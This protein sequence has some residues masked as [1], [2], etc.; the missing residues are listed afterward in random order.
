MFTPFNLVRIWRKVSQIKGI[1]LSNL[2]RYHPAWNYAIQR[3]YNMKYKQKLRFFE[4]RWQRHLVAKVFTKTFRKLKNKLN[5]HQN[6]II[7]TSGS[8][9]VAIFWFLIDYNL[10]YWIEGT[11]FITFDP[12]VR[13]TWFWC[14]FNLFF[15]FLK[16]LVNTFATRWRCHLFSKNLNFCLYFML[17]LRCMA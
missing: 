11:S 10:K 5:R 16:V 14:L 2:L 8:E 17:Y 15:N 12:D 9:V 7:C 13:M 1:G 6:Q 4:N 3:R